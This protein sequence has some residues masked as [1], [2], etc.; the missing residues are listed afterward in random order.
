MIT[1]DIILR[2]KRL[3]TPIK[4]V[5]LAFLAYHCATADVRFNPVWVAV[6]VGMSLLLVNACV[7]VKFLISKMRPTEKHS[8]DNITPEVR[9]CVVKME[10]QS[11]CIRRKP[12]LFL[13]IAGEDGFFFLPLLY[14]GINPVT[15]I[16]ASAIF[17]LMHY[18]DKPNTTLVGIFLFT[19]ANVLIVLPH[20]ILPMVLGHFILDT[21]A[22]SIAPMLKKWVETD[23]GK[24][25]NAQHQPAP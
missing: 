11:H 19:A 24:K 13:L 16:A 15:A 22:I 14:I 7:A 12:W 1:T 25:E 9:R 8:P 4:Y 23:Q 5:G 10:A 3:A 6:Y 17:A 21:I 20:G 2:A 18:R